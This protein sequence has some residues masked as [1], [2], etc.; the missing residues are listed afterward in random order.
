MVAITLE[1]LNTHTHIS[2]YVAHLFDK[3]PLWIILRT[4]QISIESAT[5]HYIPRLPSTINIHYIA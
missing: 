4:H 5:R 1:I 3:Q 2:D